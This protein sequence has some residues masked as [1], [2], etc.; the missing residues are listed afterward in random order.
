MLKQL[1]LALLLSMPILVFGQTENDKFASDVTSI[2]AIITA[3]YDVVS[4][5]SSD[6]WQFERDKYLHSENATITRL[7]E[8]GEANTHSLEA[9]YIPMGLSPKTDFYER[10]LK[11]KVRHYGNIAQVWSAFEIRTSP[12][13]ESQ[14]R[15][16]NSIQ[17]YFAKGRWWIGSWT[18]EMESV[19]NALVAN[20]LNGE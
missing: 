12:N 20:F 14:G 19:N 7:N 2:D 11:R 3:Y 17:L 16:L 9:E 5:A 13:G 8:N 10:E 6:P 1:V 18:C 4:G 15:G